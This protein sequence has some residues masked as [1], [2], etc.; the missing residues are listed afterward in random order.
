MRTLLLST[1]PAGALAAALQMHLDG[2]PRSVP[3]YELLEAAQLDPA[4][5]RDV[6]LARWRDVLVTI[7]DR[8][9]Y[10]GRGEIEG[11][12]D[13]SF[14]GL[15][16]TMALLT[17]I[18]LDQAGW[19][20]I[21]IDTAPTG[22]A[23]RLLGLPS[24][25]IALIT[26]LD[27]MQEK[28][29]FMVSALTH[30]YR[31]DEADRFLESMRERVHAFRHTLADPARFG[32]V[33]VARAELLVVEETARY[34]A[35]LDRLGIQPRAIVVNAVPDDDPTN[36][37]RGS[38]AALAELARDAAHFRV[39]LLEHPPAGSTGISRWGAVVTAGPRCSEPQARTART[40]GTP[41][42][43]PVETAS[44]GT[45]QRAYTIIPHVRSLP[46]RTLVSVVPPLTIIGGK[47]GVGKTTAAC[48][49]G[50]SI[51]TPD[52]HVLVVST[53]P[54]PSVADALAQA[55]GEEIV[56]VEGAPG[57]FAQQLDATAAFERF[58]NRYSARVDA[59]FDSLVRG[60]M[61]VAYDRRIAREL[62]ALAP[63][64]IDELYALAALGE[65]LAEGRFA[66]VIVDPAPTGHLLRLLDLPELALDWTHRLLRLT[67]EYRELVGLGEATAEL[68]AFARRT[69]AL[70]ALLRDRTCAG[71]LVVM[72]DEPLV[73]EES[74]RLLGRVHELGIAVPCAMWNR[75]ER[76]PLP[77]PTLTP[78]RQFAASLVTPPPR[79]VEALR[80]WAQDWR[81]LTS[82]AH[83]R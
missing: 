13:T 77:L 37:T 2:V 38:L 3:G 83:G 54:A 67:L 39:P 70:A 33:L 81:S 16:E 30:R 78:A 14:P 27:A 56:A 73:R 29:R 80:H 71:V 17:L 23:L 34:I 65:T 21:V 46:E 8:G 75:S 42:E 12:V 31:A 43:P 6:F 51:A 48:A 28:H 50:V 10:L 15:D 58:R 5:A 18:D 22:H 41:H 74:E 35:A 60:S 69:R 61:D 57:L 72:L 40:A 25:F 82:G 63:P 68:L 26:L 11:I 52:H 20:R 4:T 76:E 79:G 59:L 64:G 45:L 36:S 66:T 62:L 47:G 49:L 1:D 9:T 24:A 32:V 44:Q 55:V 19:E 53:D 7:L